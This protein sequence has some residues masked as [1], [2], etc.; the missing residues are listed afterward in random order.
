VR[1]ERERGIYVS[2]AQTLSKFDFFYLFAGY[3]ALEPK[4]QKL[5]GEKRFFGSQTAG[6][7]LALEFLGLVL[8]A[9]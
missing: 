3:T 8:T 5:G 4:T 6:G 7:R 1:T 2:Y 9:K